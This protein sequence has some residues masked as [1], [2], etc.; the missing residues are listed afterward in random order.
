MSS[1]SPRNL[2]PMG[3]MSRAE[4]VANL[5]AVVVPFLAM[6]AAIVLLWNSSSAAA[7]LDHRR[8][9]VPAD[10][11]RDHGRLPPPAHPPLLPD[12][13]AARVH[14]R[15]ARLDGGAGPGDRLG[16]R[17]PQAPRP[18]RRRGRPAQPPRRPRR[19]RAR[20]AARPLARPRRLADVDQ[21]RADWKKYAP[22]L[23]EDPGMRAISRLFVP[24]RARSA[25]ALPALAGYL[26]T[27]TA[28]RRRSP[29]CSG[30]GWC[31][32][33]SSTTSPGASTRSATS[34]APAASR[35]TTTPPTSSGWRC[36]RWASPGTTTTTPSR[37][38][39]STACKR[40]ELDPSALIIA[41][42]EKLGLARNVVRIAPERQAERAH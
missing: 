32:S 27:G 21:G 14:L 38:R 42:M 6:L 13:E 37:A 3:E 2:P 35:P 41:A 5:G 28:A 9:D 33:S 11:G 34:S 36:P 4:K 25:L 31:A 12:L 15:R 23:Y 7:D 19:R 8:G 29:A 26:L 10:R 30:A 20:G 18:H 40:W 39:P 22:D 17:P 16:R 24:P 1:Q